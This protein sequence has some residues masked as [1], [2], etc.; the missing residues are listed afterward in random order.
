MR[1]HHATRCSQRREN[2]AFRDQL[3]DQPP[4]P[5]AQRK[6]GGHLMPTPKSPYQQQIADVC[7][8]DQQYEQHHCDGDSKRGQQGA[9]IVERRF[10]QSKQLQALPAIGFRI[11]QLQSFCDRRKLLLRLLGGYSRL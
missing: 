4:T 5:G 10:P 7:A 6:P 11:I 1:H 3:P 9:G 2:Q 8:N